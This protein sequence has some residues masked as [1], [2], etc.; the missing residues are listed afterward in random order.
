MATLR[1][2]TPFTKCFAVMA[3][4]GEEMVL[5]QLMSPAVAKLRRAAEEKWWDDREEALRKGETCAAPESAHLPLSRRP[6]PSLKAQSLCSDLPPASPPTRRC[7]PQ[8]WAEVLGVPNM[9]D[10][11]L[12]TILSSLRS[13]TGIRQARRDGATAPVFAAGSYSDRLPR[14]DTSD[15]TGLPFSGG[16]GSSIQIPSLQTCRACRACRCAVLPPPGA[17]PGRW[18]ENL[19]RRLFAGASPGEA[20]A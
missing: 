9:T 19:H 8:P 16:R 15:L 13:A 20:G 2:F 1:F 4:S 10:Y 11:F 18:R 7:R 12:Q 6:V 3:R 17:I 5:G 14:E